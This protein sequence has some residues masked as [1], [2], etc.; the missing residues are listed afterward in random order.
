VRDGPSDRC[1][2]S[3]EVQTFYSEEQWH[4]G[5]VEDKL[6]AKHSKRNRRLALSS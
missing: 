1:D 6:V 5:Y 2:L 3:S 4:L